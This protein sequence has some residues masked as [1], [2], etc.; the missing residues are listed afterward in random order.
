M[1]LVL[2]DLRLREDGVPFLDGITAEFLR[3]RLTTVIGRTSA[4]KTTL[5]RTLAGLQGLDSGHIRLD[6]RA[7]ETVPAW[8]RDVAMVYQQFINYP[9]LSVFENVAFPLRRRGLGDAEVRQRVERQLETVGLGTFG[10]RRPSALSGGQQQ[11][12]AL[13]RAL[14]RHAPILLLDEPLVNLDYKLREQLRDEF[15][16]ILGAQTDTIAVYNTTEPA[17]AMMLGDHVVVL[18]EGRVLQTGT[19]ADVFDRPASALVAGIVNDPPMNVMEGELS[20]D[21]LNF[22]AV[23]FPRP[24]H[25][26]S[27]PPG[28]YRFGI[29]AGEIEAGQ[30]ETSGLVTYS[31]I[32]GSESFIYL[33]APFGPI[34]IQREG[35]HVVHNGSSVTFRIPPQRLFCFAGHGDGQ[36]LAAPRAASKGEH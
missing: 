2:D 20:A 9:H 19:P 17:E 1:S 30:G 14:V 16:R 7:F 24:A 10:E 8:Q 27:L 33:D 25:L 4:G 13:A 34:A 21:A 15:R 36:L 18:H 23:R 35:V 28:C 22:S 5:M 29:R 3:G 6:G 11:R 26:M 12:V 31:E 32:S